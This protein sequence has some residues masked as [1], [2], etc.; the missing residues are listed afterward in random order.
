MAERYNL[1]EIIE[2]ITQVGQGA[3]KITAGDLIEHF[4]NRG[5][6]PLLV[7]PALIAILPTGGIPGV[8]TVCG[9]L[10]CFISIQLALGKQSPWLP[11]KFKQLSIKQE[12]LEKN[13]NKALPIT[14]KIDKVFRP[15]FKLFQSK[16]VKKA[17]A[18]TC[19]GCGLI[20]IPLELLPFA[21]AIPASAI[22]STAVG[23]ATEDGL[24]III[25]LAM[26]L[27]SFAGT[28]LLIF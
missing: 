9:I 16:K 10:I 22:L 5:F 6:G 15:R 4:E 14:Q 27:M 24:F 12:S 2:Q 7:F 18:L 8:P 19:A 13:A 3:K 11:K 17:I 28:L 21:V 1:S 25:G 26:S 20:M 23:L